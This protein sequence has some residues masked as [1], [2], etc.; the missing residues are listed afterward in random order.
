M[1]KVSWKWKAKQYCGGILLAVVCSAPF[2]AIGSCI[3]TCNYTE[4]I[5]TTGDKTVVVKTFSFCNSQNDCDRQ[6]GE[7]NKF[8]ESKFSCKDKVRR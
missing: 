6:A 4:L 2:F 3:S 8:S 1:K 7:L 5:R